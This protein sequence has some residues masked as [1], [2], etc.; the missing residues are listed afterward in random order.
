MHGIDVH[1]LCVG[2]SND[3]SSGCLLSR[4]IKKTPKSDRLI[5]AVFP[6]F[7]SMMEA[8]RDDQRKFEEELAGI[9]KT[10]LAKANG[11]SM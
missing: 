7:E 6:T 9:E 4:F 2:A 11:L 8:V 5:A 10:E 1:R 3:T